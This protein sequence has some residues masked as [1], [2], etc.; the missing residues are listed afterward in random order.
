M[1]NLPRPVLVEQIEVNEPEQTD[2]WLPGHKRR[3]WRKIMSMRKGKR[4]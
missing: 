4:E 2:N 1:S 3:E